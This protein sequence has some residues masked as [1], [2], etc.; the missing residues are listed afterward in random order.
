MTALYI[1]IGVVLF[2]AAMPIVSE[3]IVEYIVRD[4]INNTMKEEL[5]EEEYD[6][7]G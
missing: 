3:E 6:E 5:E 1:L 2:L 4:Y 7:A